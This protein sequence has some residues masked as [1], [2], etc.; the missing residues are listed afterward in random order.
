MLGSRLS[1]IDIKMNVCIW[2]LRCS[3][4]CNVVVMGLYEDVG[5]GIFLGGWKWEEVWGE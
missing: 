2:V 5:S 1:V 4:E 3:F